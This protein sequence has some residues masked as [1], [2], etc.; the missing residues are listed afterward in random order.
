MS[1][2]GQVVRG[3]QILA[4]IG[5]GSHSTVYKA[6]HQA[7]GSLVAI[8][9]LHAKYTQD[10]QFQRRFELE[11]E[12]IARLQHPHIL[13]L[14]DYW[15]DF[16]GAFHVL[17]L[18]DGGTLRD[19]LDRYG[20]LRADV[21]LTIAQALLAALGTAHEAGIV[22]R[23]VKPA[24]ILFDRDAHVYLG[25]FGIAKKQ[26]VDLTRPGTIL[27]SP[28]YLAPEQL[29]D[30]GVTP[31]TDIYTMG[32]NVF[33]MLAGQHPFGKRKAAEMLRCQLE[34][35]L[36]ALHA[37]RPELSPDVDQVLQIATAKNPQD[38]FPDTRSF[39][40]ALAQVL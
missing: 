8:K 14:Y 15:R 37:L 3:Y 34:K 24:N 12:T 29:R 32:L 17:K 23:D 40:E 38:R 9:A 18:V 4:T 11:A 19:L 39:A 27:G 26:D 20:A 28:A 7:D 5:S 6:R 21:V 30:S 1:E 31:R 16:T 22:H 2:T 33:E 13:P 36:P 35:R 10:E 25:D